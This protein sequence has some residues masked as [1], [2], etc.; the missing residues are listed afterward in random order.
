[1]IAEDAMKKYFIIAFSL[2]V[3]LLAVNAWAEGQRD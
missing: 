3:G 1:M 2:T